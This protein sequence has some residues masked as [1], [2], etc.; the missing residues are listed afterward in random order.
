MRSQGTTSAALL[1]AFVLVWSASSS[2]QQASPHSQGEAPTRV[3]K[4]DAKDKKDAKD[5]EKEKDKSAAT[6][7]AQQAPG[8]NAPGKGSSASNTP[9]NPTPP[10]TKREPQI[11]LE[12]R[13]SAS[14]WAFGVMTALVGILLA[15]ILISLFLTRKTWTLA[16]ALSEESP[17][18]P[19]VI[20]QKSDVILLASSSRLI[21]LAG[22][23]GILTV[24]LGLGYFIVWSLF[25]TGSCPDLKNLSSF[26]L[27]SASLF[28]PYL[29]NQLREAIS[30]S[31]K[32]DKG[33]A[34]GQPAAKIPAV[35][36]AG[37]PGAAADTAKTD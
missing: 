13:E 5:K 11:P 14:L 22:L 31:E 32:K 19:A 18:Q 1:M 15:A 6:G 36:A 28:A 24:V 34:A 4:A 33:I 20:S 27:A 12:R 21:A 2:G 30:P 8:D 7:P 10:E 25:M 35:G 17:H 26:L 3:A 37:A 16:D 23:M 9:A 29:A